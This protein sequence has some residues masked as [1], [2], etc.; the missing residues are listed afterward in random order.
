M[1]TIGILGGMGSYATVEIFRRIVD[2][3][4]AEKEWE[5]P[6][7]VIDNNCA[8]PSRVRAILYGEKRNQLTYEMGESI[9]HLVDSGAS[10]ILIG[11]ITAHCFLEELPY[12]NLIINA[13]EETSKYVPTGT[14]TILCTEGTMDVG[15]WDKAL[16]DCDVIYPNSTQMVQLREFIE[17]V[18]QGKITEEKRRQ[19]AEY[20]NSFPGDTLLL[21]CTEL[22]VLLGNQISEKNI[23]DPIWCAIEKVKKIL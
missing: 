5:R 21:G 18:K 10:C 2:A 13:I 23:I 20:V 8:M 14:V 7:I 4:P 17:I 9:R 3:F 6:R 16:K 22:P 19:F 15:I 11:C 12:Q 1:Q